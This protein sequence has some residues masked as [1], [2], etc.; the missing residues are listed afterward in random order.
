MK[1]H[2]TAAFK[3]TSHDQAGYGEAD[4][5]PPLSRINLR[6]ELTGDLVGKCTA[7]QRPDSAVVPEKVQAMMVAYDRTVAHYAV[8]E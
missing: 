7:E 3:N 4:G 2:A 1:H 5:G 8:L 6:R